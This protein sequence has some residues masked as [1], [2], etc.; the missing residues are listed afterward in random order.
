MRWNVA[1][2][3]NSTNVTNVVLV[4]LPQT[5]VSSSINSVGGVA[6]LDDL[7]V[8]ASYKVFHSVC[9]LITCM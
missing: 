4:Y 3:S 5:S 8:L 6:V 2:S 7:G 9:S 1:H